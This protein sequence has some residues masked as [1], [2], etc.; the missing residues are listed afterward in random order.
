M[1]VPL[2]IRGH[3]VNG[4]GAICI[5]QHMRG[6]GQLYTWSMSMPKKQIKDPKARTTEAKPEPE[7]A[8]SAEQEQVQRMQA[9]RRKNEIAQAERRIQSL[10]RQ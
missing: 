6:V 1:A 10:S 9:L 2:D 7:S 5:L 8:K 3:T 4:C